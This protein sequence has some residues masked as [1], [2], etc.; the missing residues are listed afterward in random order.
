MKLFNVKPKLFQFIES[1]DEIVVEKYS[2]FIDVT[3]PL[4]CL[5]RDSEI[6]IHTTFKVIH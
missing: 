2:T 3:V 4:Q 6:I 1:L 5:V